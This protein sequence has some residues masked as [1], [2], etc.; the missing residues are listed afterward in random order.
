MDL[1]KLWPPIAILLLT[2][3]LAVSWLKLSE[4]LQDV[5]V[6]SSA[7]GPSPS[8]ST[9]KNWEYPSPVTYAE[10]L[11]VA[12]YGVIEAPD[13][14]VDPLAWRNALR[15]PVAARPTFVFLNACDVGQAQSQANFVEG[16]APT[17]LETGAAGFVGGLWPLP[18]E[19]AAAFAIDFYRRLA[20]GA[21]T[22]VVVAEALRATRA[23]FYATGD[24]TYLAYAYYGD[25]NLRVT[26]PNE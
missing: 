18:D 17:M 9:S 6:A 3:T 5:E 25:P 19:S 24:P 10:R 7:A 14:D 20:A 22:G 23:Q 26:I 8:L 15:K 12:R 1:K 2:V 13:G 4:G 11:G 16:W 21:K